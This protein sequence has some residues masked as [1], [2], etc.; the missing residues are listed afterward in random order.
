MERPRKKDNDGFWIS[1]D[2]WL[3]T[4]LIILFGVGFIV[5]PLMGPLTERQKGW[6]DAL[7]FGLLILIFLPLIC[8]IIRAAEIGKKSN[9]RQDKKDS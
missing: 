2:K 4:M 6:F 5:R 3:W 8:Y 1:T 7:A 9:D